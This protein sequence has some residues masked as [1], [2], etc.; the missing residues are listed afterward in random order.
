MK[1]ISKRLKEKR[2][3]MIKMRLNLK[4][5]HWNLEGMFITTKR[6]AKN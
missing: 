6:G 5:K 3:V 1:K 2:H 4:L